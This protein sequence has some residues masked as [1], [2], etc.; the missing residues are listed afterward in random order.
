MGVT[1]LI[2]GV[3]GPGCGED[4]DHGEDSQLCEPNKSVWTTLI[5]QIVYE[6]ALPNSLV[7]FYTTVY[8]K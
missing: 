8:L 2:L 3:S 1:G 7:S 6:K 5:A 4:A